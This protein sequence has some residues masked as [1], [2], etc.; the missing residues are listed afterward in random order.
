MKIFNEKESVYYWNVFHL[1]VGVSR[2]GGILMEL[3]KTDVVFWW[4]T[5]IFLSEVIEVLVRKCLS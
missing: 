4:S 3:V 5:D 1:G 2:S